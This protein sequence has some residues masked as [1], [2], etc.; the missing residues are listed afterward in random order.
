MHLFSTFSALGTNRLMPEETFHFVFNK[1]YFSHNN[2]S[3]SDWTS[4]TN[5]K[6]PLRYLRMY[7]KYIS[8][9]RNVWQVQ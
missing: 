3:L 4:K 9:S 1:L 7:R 5:Q 2:H 8:T 6:D